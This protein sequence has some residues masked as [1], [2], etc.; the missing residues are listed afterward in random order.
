M[1]DEEGNN[2]LGERIVGRRVGQGLGEN[3]E[4]KGRLRVRE[5]SVSS[6]TDVEVDPRLLNARVYIAPG[7]EFLAVYISDST[8][9]TQATERYFSQ[10]SSLMFEASAGEEARHIFS[11]GDPFIENNVND[12]PLRSNQEENIVCNI[13]DNNQSSHEQRDEERPIVEHIDVVEVVEE[14]ED[15]PH[16]DGGLKEN[17]SILLLDYRDVE[18]SK[19]S[20]SRVDSS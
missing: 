17:E 6:D 11:P 4:R 8:C 18:G 14:R 19:R 7:L 12:Q 20:H 1:S 10:S 5:V 15:I 3:E 9:S 16:S 13:S 2:L